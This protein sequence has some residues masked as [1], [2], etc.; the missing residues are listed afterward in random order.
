MPVNHPLLNRPVIGP[1][2]ETLGMHRLLP[3]AFERRDMTALWQHTIQRIEADVG[4][5]AAMID[6]SMMLYC[7]FRADEARALL[8]QAVALQ[9]DFCIV[10]GDGSGLK[11]LA[12]VTPG[13]F[14]ANTP[15]DFLLNG[16]DAVLWLRYVDA[17]T[18]DLDGLPEHDVALLAIGEATEHRA[19]LARMAELLPTLGGPVMNADPRR[20]AGLTRDDVSASL[21]AEASLCVPPTTKVDRAVLESIG[22]GAT[23]LA[24]HVASLAFPIIVRPLGTHAGGGLDRLDSPDAALAYLATDESAKFF[25]APFIDYRGND[26]LFSK[27]RV[28]FIGGKAFPS[29][30]AL[31]DHWIVHYLSAGMAENADKRAVEAAWME[32][33]D[34]DFA[35]RHAAAFAALNRRI[36][37]DYFGIDCAELPDGRLLIFEVDVAMLVHDMDDGETFPYKKVAMQKLFDAFVTYAGAL[38]GVGY[39]C[40]A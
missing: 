35:H 16:S 12:F 27:Q 28:V 40:A 39:E 6:L 38:R 21:A 32:H 2:T 15:V 29:H 10:H 23:E 9:R 36:G 13:D 14:M 25:I 18:A 7:H 3:M 22:S 19:V 5:A 30:L 17:D 1:R 26:G 4:D 8:D 34:T 37:L 11:V 20:I 33:F 24:D 31:S